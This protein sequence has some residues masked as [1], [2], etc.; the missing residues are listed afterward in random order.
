VELAIVT[1]KGQSRESTGVLYGGLG[2]SVI[3]PNSAFVLYVA[4]AVI[5]HTS[6]VLATATHGTSSALKEGL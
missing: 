3:E 6:R 5:L 1:E 2:S 4:V